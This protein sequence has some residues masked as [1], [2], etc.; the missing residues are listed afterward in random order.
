MGSLS[1]KVTP[2]TMTFLRILGPI[3]RRLGRLLY[4]G[5]HHNI[6]VST[7]TQA[8]TVKEK[9]IEE[10]WRLRQNLALSYRI[11]DQLQLNEGSC[12]HLSVMA[13]ARDE[14]DS[15]VML[16]APGYL[17][18]GGGIDWSRVTAS[19]LLGL[20]PDAEVLEGEGLPE[21]SGAVIHLGVRKA[22]PDARVVMHTHTPYATALGCLQDPS[23]IM[24]H[25]TSCRFKDRLAFDWGYQPATQLEEGERLGK[26]LGDKD[27]LFMCHHGT[28]VVAENIH[29]AFDEVY[30]LERACMLQLLA[31]GAEG[32]E[33]IKI[34]P[35]NVQKDTF[36][37]A[38]GENREI[39]DKYAMKH[40]YARWNK[41]KD[42]GSDVF[43]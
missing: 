21:L 23:L 39:L 42:E 36:A 9:P 13:P 8:V 20:G 12:N 14:S 22:R 38:M 35:E 18:H 26:V 31:M 1:L 29:I 24:M 4:I 37:T 2:M 32:R 17:P 25:Q 34:L 33:A 16:I 43:L 6:S 7:A 19:C 28:L 27:I 11:F 5:V 40:F 10:N 41:Y 30:Y 15:E 3:P